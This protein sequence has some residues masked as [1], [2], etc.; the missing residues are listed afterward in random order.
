[1]KN[2]ENARVKIPALV[3][4]T[5]LGYEYLSLKE[6]DGGIHEENITMGQSP[7]GES[8]NENG[9]GKFF[10]KVVPI[11]VPVFLPSEYIQQHRQDLQK[12]VKF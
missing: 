6:Y 9:D 11:S 2:N 5:R 12:Q 10:T 8:Y 7:A 3:H 4:L 1:M